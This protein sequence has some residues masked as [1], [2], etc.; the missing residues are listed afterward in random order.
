VAKFPNQGCFT[1]CHTKDESGK[2]YGNKFFE[3]QGEIAD[4][5]H[6]KSVRNVN[7]V[8]DQYVD[9]STYDKEKSPEAGRH[10]DPKE[11]GGYADNVTEDKSGPQ[12]GLPD[13]KP[14]PPYQILD[15]EKVAF[16]ATKYQP[17]DEV[18]GIVASLITGDRGN[19]AAGWKY[20]DGKW[21]IEFGR[22][23]VTGSEYDVQFNDLG[24]VYYFGLAIFDNAQVRH[25]FGAH[26]VPFVFKP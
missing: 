24:T 3:N 5:W 26:P 13:N 17:G 7:Q 10:S 1:A 21:T 25:A 2:P 8:D 18:P 11:G 22:K 12:F 15:S 23:L 6:W 19:I 9:T 20:A 14:A 16:D 4:L